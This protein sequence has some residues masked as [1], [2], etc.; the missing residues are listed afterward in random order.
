MK[1]LIITLLFILLSCPVFAENQQL[2]WMGPVIAGSVTASGLS[3]TSGTSDQSNTTTD[4][5]IAMPTSY[6]GQSFQ[7]SKTGYIHSIK[8]RGI[9]NSNGTGK[10]TLRIGNNIDLTTYWKEVQI[11]ETLETSVA[12]TLIFEIKDTDNQVSAGTTYY[13]EV[14]ET[15]GG[16]VFQAYLSTSN[17][18]A[19]GT[20]YW[21]A[22]SNKWDLTGHDDIGDFSFDILICD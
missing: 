3:C 13:F 11:T 9:G 21:S 22:D 5:A 14:S 16:A 15:A 12:K 4:S 1:K 19:S 7:V 6:M 18:Y 8:V 10:F 17:T 20:G 2:A